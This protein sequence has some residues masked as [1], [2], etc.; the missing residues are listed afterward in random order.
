MTGKADPWG[1]GTVGAEPG[2]PW[3]D[4]SLDDEAWA[5]QPQ[6]ES[7]TAEWREPSSPVHSP[8]RPVADAPQPRPARVDSKPTAARSAEQV[9]KPRKR[10][11]SLF[12]GRTAD[13]DHFPDEALKE[14]VRRPLPTPRTIAFINEGGGTGKTTSALLLGLTLASLRGGPIVAVD[15]SPGCGDLA[16]RV[17]APKTPAGTVRTVVDRAAQITTYEDLRKHTNTL[18]DGL[19]V[20]AADSSMSAD[21]VF[22]GAAYEKLV[23]L[24]RR[25][26]EL[27]ITDCAAGMVS[28]VVSA[29][30]DDAD[31]VVIVSE[32]GDGVRSSTWTANWMLEHAQRNPRYKQLL[33]DA[34]VVVNSRHDRTNA[35]T[36]KIVDFYRGV[37]RAVVELPFD[38]HLEGGNIV[39]MKRLSP[40][41]RHQLARFAG[42]VMAASGITD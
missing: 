12:K 14:S 35:N 13:A 4:R 25:H 38:Q 34:V 37:V 31:V 26:Y 40:A 8:A 17:P 3:D 29:V 42:A 2:N 22:T 7:D 27:V 5:A 10:W 6:L 33:D 18:S 28:D 19:D 21:A 11:R 30:H 16:N 20:L 1:D 39:E 32:G 15:A 24:L 41:T 23:A 36:A 9:E